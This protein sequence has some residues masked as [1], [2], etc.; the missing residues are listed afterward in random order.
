[1]SLPASFLDE[2]RMRLPVSEI[3]GRRVRLT[4]AGREYKGLCPFHGEKSP[5]FYVNDAKQFYHCFGCGAHGDVIT[6]M[7][8]H[9]KLSF[10]EAIET[11]AGLAGMEVPKADPQTRQRYEKEKSLGDLLDQAT[12]FFQAQLHT[13][14]GREARGYLLERG[15]SEDAISRF[16]LGYAPTDAQALPKALKTEGYA[17][18]DMLAVGL[19]KQGDDGRTYSFFRNRVIFPVGDRRG[20]VVAFGARLMS[21]EGPKYIN[22]PDHPLFHKGKLLYGLSRA[23]AAAAEGQPLI[24]V[25][26]YMDVIA[27]AES[28]YR[29]AVAPLGTAL[30]EEQM[31]QLWK[32]QPRLEDRD[33]SR[34]YSPILCFDGDAAGQRAANRAID[35]ALPLISA[36][37]TLRIAFMP[38]GE[39]PDSLIRRNGKGAMQNV[40]DQAKPLADMLWEQALA[41]RRLHTPEDKAALRAV[42]RGTLSRIADENLRR[43][44][45]EEMR[46]RLAAFAARP[47]PPYG[48]QQ[49][50][51]GRSEKGKFGGK[52]YPAP[53]PPILHRPQ[54]MGRDMREKVLLRTML[55]HPEL[56]EEFGESLAHLA[57]AHPDT[58]KLRHHLVEV[59]T[60]HAYEH[61]DAEEIFRHFEGSVRNDD[62]TG[63]LEASLSDLLS[64]AI[65]SFAGF[66]RPER[67]PEEASQG[68][69]DIWAHYMR[70]KLQQDLMDAK[71]RYDAEPTEDNQRRF[72]ALSQELVAMQ[73]RQNDED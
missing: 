21:G 13:P 39:D 2:L 72:Y 47:S 18:A 5:S 10:P 37:Q 33:P 65:Y 22:S 48:G 64:E 9:D 53:P 34:D 40:L 28:G 45:G 1:M 55:N 20:N 42:L 29:G 71:T 51:F 62:P 63:T 46:D 26:G 16:R 19:L 56:F 36:A 52:G 3:V 61:L 8:S 15:L 12:K 7:M 70:E 44:Y 68:W 69:K 4:K 14:T 17:E 49:R 57:F 31:L 30:T 6:F 35:R 41:G 66:A 60:L 24:V 54:P 23:R 58:E 67:S 43:L 50:P 59:L 11:L 27:L 25:E 73:S 32:L 38:T